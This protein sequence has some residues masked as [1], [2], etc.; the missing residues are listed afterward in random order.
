MAKTATQPVLSR[1]LIIIRQITN[2]DL[3]PTEEE[4]TFIRELFDWEESSKHCNAR[5]RK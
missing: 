3:M 4:K 5:F 1:P 2:E